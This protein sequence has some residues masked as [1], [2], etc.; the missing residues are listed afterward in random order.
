MKTATIISAIATVLLLLTAMICGL[1]IRANNVSAPE[2][3]NFHVNAGIG[4][5]VFA[6]I[7][8]CLAVSAFSKSKK[9]G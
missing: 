8:L 1:W 4:A 5:V 7:T 6:T 2:S 3:L 9:K